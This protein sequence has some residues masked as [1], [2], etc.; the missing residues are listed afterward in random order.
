MP[1]FDVKCEVCGLENEITRKISEDNP[2]CNQCGGKTKTFFP[3]GT[4]L[5]NTQFKG[6]GWADSG[7]GGTK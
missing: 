3:M 4:K 6:K 1:K 2:P 7:K 5:N